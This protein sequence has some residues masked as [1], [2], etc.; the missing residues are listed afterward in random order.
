MALRFVALAALLWIGAAE[1]PAVTR[2]STH[3]GCS[4]RTC[5]ELGWS[6]FGS[7][8]VC[9]E[10]DASPLAGCSGPVNWAAA[11]E[12]C[13]SVGGRLCA[14]HELAAARGAGCGSH[15]EWSRTACGEDAFVARRGTGEECAA[16][17]EL[18]FA[19]CCADEACGRRLTSSD[20]STYAELRSA[21][22]SA[23]SG[24]WIPVRASM[25]F[26]TLI[27][28]GTTWSATPITITGATCTE[29]LDG[30]GSTRFFT[31]YGTLNLECL[32][33]QNGYAG[34]GSVSGPSLRAIRTSL[35]GGHVP[36]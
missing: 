20:V 30:G 17:G 29:V 7:P 25:T 24:S 15:G 32:T 11:H 5:A 18:Y 14:A 8:G 33:L 23:D 4:A 6:S 35:S 12:A 10:L 9:V 34:Y 26:T 28:I 27:R 19:R 2:D 16:S 3:V 21:V 22:A 36:S 31:V 13:E 1:A